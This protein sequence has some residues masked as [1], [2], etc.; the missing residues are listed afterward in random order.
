VFC[1]GIPTPKTSSGACWS[2]PWTSSVR[3]SGSR[4]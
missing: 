2:K 1:P 3:P 4:R